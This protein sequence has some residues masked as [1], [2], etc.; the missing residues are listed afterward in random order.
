[1]QNKEIFTKE[2]V[3]EML[4]KMQMETV[5]CQGFIIGHVT[6]LWVIRE[7]LGK[8]I[9]ELGEKGIDIAIK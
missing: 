4:R 7:M 5:R 8:R 6:Q 1:M 9:E 2:E 3:C